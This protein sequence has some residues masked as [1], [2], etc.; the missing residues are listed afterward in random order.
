M[1]A[2]ERNDTCGIE[3]LQHPPNSPDSAPSDFYFF[4]K[5]NSRLPSRQSGNKLCCRGVF[6]GPEGNILPWGHCNA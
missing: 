5:L 4:L 3:L 1:P 2:K 6:G